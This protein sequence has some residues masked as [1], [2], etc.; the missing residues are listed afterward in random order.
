MP[1]HPDARTVD[2]IDVDTDGGTDD[3]T[4]WLLTASERANPATGIPAWT[5]GNLAEPLVHGAVYF[6]RLVDAVQDLQAGDHLFFTDWRGDP[7]QQLRPGGPTVDELFSAG[8]APRGLRPRAGVALALGRAELQQ[9]GERHRWTAELEADGAVIVLD[10][11]VRRM[12]SHHQKFVV[13][14]HPA[15]PRRGTSRSPAA[16]TS[17]TAAATTTEHLR[18]PAAP[19]DVLGLR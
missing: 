14:R 3:A 4:S 18:R 11:R 6:D 7:D 13:C 8:R 17:G 5:A 1:D 9:G 16:S 12:G 2:R 19:V 15:G 10:Q